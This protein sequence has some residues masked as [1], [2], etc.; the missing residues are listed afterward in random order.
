MKI[1]VC[2]PPS[3]ILEA[4]IDSNPNCVIVDG[5]ESFAEHSDAGAYINLHDNAM[6]FT[7]DTTSP[8]LVNSVLETLPS[9]KTGLYRINAW[10][11][12]LK[13]EIWE[14]AGLRSEKVAGI[15]EALGKKLVWVKDEPGFVSARVISMIVNEAFFAIADKISTREEIDIAMKLGTGYP[16]GPFEWAKIIGQQRIGKLLQLLALSDKRYQPSILLT[17]D[18]EHP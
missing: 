2:G 12:F 14:I 1:V 16:Y 18:I 11:G 15:A 6:S 5:V 3:A 4:K 13:R 17:G 10:P 8:V 7:Y 9:N